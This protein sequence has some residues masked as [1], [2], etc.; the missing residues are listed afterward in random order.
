MAVTGPASFGSLVLTILAVDGLAG[1]VRQRLHAANRAQLEAGFA[2]GRAAR[3]PGTGQPAVGTK[4]GAASRRADKQ[5]GGQGIGTEA[6]GRIFP[7]LRDDDLLA[8]DRCDGRRTGWS[9]QGNDSP[10]RVTSLRC[11]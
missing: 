5:A 4:R 11:P 3:L 8:L 10:D 7:T 9:E 1:A 2:A 6:H